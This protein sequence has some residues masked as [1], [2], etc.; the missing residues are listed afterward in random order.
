MK[1]SSNVIV[2][3]IFVI[4][5]YTV[6]TL[7]LSKSG[8]KTVSEAK[9]ATSSQQVYQYLVSRGYQVYSL[10]QAKGSSD[11]DAK[12]YINGV[13]S[14]THIHVVGSSIIDNTDIPM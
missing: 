3:A 5:L 6:S 8:V 10:V 13:Y 7:L 12:I 9:A 11:W 2:K 4:V 1:K 14:I